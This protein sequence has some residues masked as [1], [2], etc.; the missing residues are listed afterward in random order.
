[1]RHPPTECP[2]R[3]STAPTPAAAPTPVQAWAPQR[4]APG[5]GCCCCL[6]LQHQLRPPQ[7]G[8]RDEVCHFLRIVEF[9]S[10]GLTVVKAAPATAPLVSPR[11]APEAAPPAAP[12]FAGDCQ[13]L[14]CSLL[15]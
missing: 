5:N 6:L 4:A 10:S 9:R 11:A 12:A 1:M 7:Q 2:T 8:P 15:S 13:R 14:P 3:L